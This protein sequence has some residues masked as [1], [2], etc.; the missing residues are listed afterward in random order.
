MVTLA[1]LA[2]LPRARSRQVAGTGMWSLALALLA[3]VAG[4]NRI[5]TLS[6]YQ[7]DPHLA[8]V[9]LAELLIMLAA[10]ALVVPDAAR[11]QTVTPA[12][13]PSPRA[14]AA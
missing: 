4:A 5:L 7:N 10:V 13:P 3:A 6:S 12:P 1:C 2:H 9:S 8:A 14:S 11:T